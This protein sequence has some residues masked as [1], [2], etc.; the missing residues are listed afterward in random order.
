MFVAYTAIGGVIF[1]YFE[2]WSYFEAF[3][4]SFITMATVGFG[5]IVPTEQVPS[6][7][8]SLPNPSGLHDYHHRLHHLRLV[9]RHH[10]H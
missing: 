7:K 6:S 8:P 10:V 1:R 4:F 9:P 3:Y 2:G 5:D